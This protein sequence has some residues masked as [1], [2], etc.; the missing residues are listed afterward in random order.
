MYVYD[1][2]E[3]YN[4]DQDYH[5][6]CQSRGMFTLE[7]DADLMCAVVNDY[8]AHYTYSVV[9]TLIDIN[10]DKLRKGYTQYKCER[11]ENRSGK[12]QITISAGNGTYMES[13]KPSTRLRID[14]E[15]V[16]IL[17]LDAKHAKSIYYAERRRLKDVYRKD[18]IKQGRYVILEAM[19]QCMIAV[20][21][22]EFFTGSEGSLMNTS[23]GSLI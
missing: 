9:A 23:I 11:I 20:T 13:F 5:H 3:D 8:S 12:T 17:A 4:N 14:S 15:C 1:V 7:S 19:D 18:L 10:I 6:V 22:D 21:D 16:Y 2:M